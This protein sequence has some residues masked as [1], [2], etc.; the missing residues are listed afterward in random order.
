MIPWSIFQITERSQD[1][2]VIN[3]LL[4]S[5]RWL[6]PECIGQERLRSFQT[7]VYMFGCCLWEMFVRLPPFHFLSNLEELSQARLDDAVFFKPQQQVP[8]GFEHLEQI[9]PLIESCVATTDQ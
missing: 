3:N 9:L 6:A 2:V 1:M 8:E 7:D 4:Q 5:L